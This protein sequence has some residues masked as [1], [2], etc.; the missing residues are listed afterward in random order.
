[1]A[2]LPDEELYEQAEIA[3]SEVDYHMTEAEREAFIE[4]WVLER[5]ALLQL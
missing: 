4:R 2:P 3:A 1:M 5:Q